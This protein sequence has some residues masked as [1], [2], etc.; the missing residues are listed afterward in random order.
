MDT[1]F[2]PFTDLNPIAPACRCLPFDPA[3]WDR[4]HLHFR[5][6][7][8]VHAQTRC[9]LHIPLNM[10]AVFDETWAAISAADAI[11]PGFVI[12]SDDQSLWRGH[13]YFAVRHEVPGLEA[14]RLS[15]DFVTRVFEG[16]Y[17]HAYI[18]VREMQADI[19][20]A[21]G[22]MGRLFF[23]YTSCPKCAERLGH[24]YVVGIGEVISR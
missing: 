12:L 17:R 10:G 5:D 3:K 6:K 15:G 9:V 20:E 7:L 8:F 23:Y 2:L 16:P 14:V 24:N 1:N 19:E 4:L 22:K 13:H 18:W 11:D 21:G